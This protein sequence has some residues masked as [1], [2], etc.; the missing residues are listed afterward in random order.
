MS[1]KVKDVT[2]RNAPMA[3]A[4]N[5]GELAITQDEIGIS[6]NLG[7]FFEHLLIHLLELDFVSEAKERPG[8]DQRQCY[9]CCE[10][11]KF[12]PK[13]KPN[14]YATNK[15]ENSL[16]NHSHVDAKKLL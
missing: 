8:H 4:A 6:S 2:V 10:Q 12:P 14:R 5:C 11:C 1:S 3:S 15:A 9:K 7:A 16:K 13:G